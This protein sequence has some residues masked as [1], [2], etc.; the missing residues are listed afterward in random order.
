MT[1]HDYEMLSAALANAR[2]PIHPPLDRSAWQQW[3][4]D[5]EYIAQALDN[6]SRA[7]DSERFIKDCEGTQS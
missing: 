4:I 2:P 1:R 5:C 6:Q 7:F 3:L